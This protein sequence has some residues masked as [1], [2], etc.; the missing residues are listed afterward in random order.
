M[1]ILIVVEIGVTVE[2]TAVVRNL[3]DDVLPSKPASVIVYGH[4]LAR[5]RLRDN[6]LYPDGQCNAEF[7]R[8]CVVELSRGTQHVART[9]SNEATGNMGCQS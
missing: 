1:G 6:V 2:S 5:G 9:V 7:P 8:R 4:V 3:C